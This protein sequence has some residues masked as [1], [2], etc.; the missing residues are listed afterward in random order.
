MAG[1]RDREGLLT[2]GQSQV[3]LR[4]ADTEQP[5]RPVRKMLWPQRTDITGADQTD[6]AAD[7]YIRRWS[8]SNWERGEVQGKWQP[9]A[10]G[11]STNIRPDRVG[12]RLILGAYRE[13]TTN[14]TP[15]TFADGIRF[16]RAQGLLWACDDTP[17]TW[18]QVA[19][20]NWDATGWATGATTQTA[21]SL[22]DAGDGSNIL[23]SLDDKSVRKVA[24]GANSELI[25]AATPTYAQELRYSNGTVYALDG[26]N[27]YSVNTTTGARTALST[28]GGR[29]AYYMASAGN[30]WRRLT[31][32]DAGVAWLL[33]QDDGSTIIME[34]NSSTDTDA[35]IGILPVEFA[36]PYSIDFAHGFIFV[37]YR[38]AAQHGETGEARIYYQRG[39]QRGSTP[40]IRLVGTTTASQP[41]IIA[42]VIGDD[43]IF[44]YAKAIWAY[45]LSAG[46]VYQLAQSAA[47]APTTVKD[48]ET[49]G[50]DT[51][52]ANLNGNGQ[53]ERFDSLAYS[54]DAATWRSGRFAFDF[55]GIR[56]ALLRVTVVVDPLPA[57]TSLTMAVSAD[58]GSFT[59]LTGTFN[60]DDET[61]YTWTASSS[62]PS[63]SQIVGYDF[64]LRLGMSTTTS[65]ATPQIREIFAEAVSAQ[66]RRGLEL[67]V[68]VKSG[69]VGRAAAGT[70]L[71]SQLAAAAEYSGGIVE[72]TDP[73]G[74]ADTETPKTVDVIVELLAGGADQ[75]FATLRLWET[76]V[77]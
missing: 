25:A 32:T 61:T 26:A 47:G 15:A 48:A 28:P 5:Y 45:D 72:L 37:G 4:L 43:L 23:I 33:P 8:M 22:C 67:D 31:V 54:T 6:Q 7:V 3:R 56:K 58:G 62:G 29:V 53:V 27:L 2:Y 51:F 46:A 13:V 19:T 52:I 74:V 44:Y 66:K 68:S 11:Q 20:A 12:D 71:L 40:P 35:Q 65:T 30:M 42:G 38:Y 36:F 57:A 76:G 34:Y 39:G 70:Q 59:T 64:E 41:V 69:Q 73:W 75:E 60:T 1:Y 55:P 63:T 18:W 16:G 9:G 50:K 77:V 24:S 49:Y 14:D 21:V 17:V 10:Y